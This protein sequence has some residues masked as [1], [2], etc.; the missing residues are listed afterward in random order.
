MDS[1]FIVVA[2]LTSFIIR[3][4]GEFPKV[5]FSAYKS[6]A[7]FIVVSRICG[8]Y[9]F[10][11]YDKPK[12][13][14]NFEILINTL[15]A[16]S[17]SSLIIFLFLYFLNIETY[18]RSIAIL[19]WSLTTIAIVAWRF[20][21]KDFIGLY[22]GQNFFRS[23]LLIIGTGSQARETAQQALSEAAVEYNLVGFLRSG[24]EP[25]VVDKN[26]VLGEMEEISTIIKNIPIDEVIIA[27]P[28]LE[29]SEIAKIMRL[30][31]Q[32]KIECKSLP[33]AYETIISNIAT[34]S[35]ETAFVG[36]AIFSN[37]P[38]AWYWRLKRILDIIASIL[39]LII[40][41]PV[42]LLAIILIKITSPGPVFYFQKRTGQNSK[43][44]VMYKL[45]T[46]HVA[47]ERRGRARWAK[48]GDSRITPAGKILRR[49]R[50]DELPQLVNILKNEM[51]LVGPRP[52]RPFFTTKLIKKIPFFAL[53]F[54]VKP[55]LTGWAQ[56]NFKYAATE[57]EAEK[58]LVYDLFYVQNMSF[59]LDTLIALKTF[60]VI[61]T[62]KGAQ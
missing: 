13:K 53:R 12:Y 3:F 43:P 7:F 58:K 49:F 4:N 59:A 36:P 44:F 10:H 20:V 41:F 50:I 25:V 33:S 42:L 9:V 32:R 29:K 34:H 62:G 51:S 5:N 56:I 18:P 40:T 11:L 17:A 48:Q 39:I 2:D 60:N 22:L 38:A 6:L 21:T 47:S 19:S 24:K 45:R 30:L 16:C 57:E 54:K 14:S 1:L 31:S 61:V 55:G 52:E 35:G 26:K 28:N 37:T 15:K 23:N 27:D 8:F 46:M